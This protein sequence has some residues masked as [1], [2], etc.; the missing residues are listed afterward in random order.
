MQ[1]CKASWRISHFLWTIPCNATLCVQLDKC[2]CMLCYLNV[3]QQRH[4]EWYLFFGGFFCWHPWIKQLSHCLCCR[5]NQSGG[6]GGAQSWMQTSRQWQLHEAEEVSVLWKCW[7][8]CCCCCASAV[9]CVQIEPSSDLLLSPVLVCQTGH[10]S[11]CLMSI[12]SI[13]DIVF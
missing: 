5:W 13:H 4:V 11:K 3:R 10:W 12:S 6:D 1:L 2:V 8:R 7:P 9:H